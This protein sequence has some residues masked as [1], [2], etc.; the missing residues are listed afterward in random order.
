ATL[1]A[2]A[3]APTFGGGLRIAPDAV[4]DDGLMDVVIADELTPWQIIRLFPRLYNGS[5]VSNPAVHMMRARQV[6]IEP[7]PGISPPRVFG[8]GEDLSAL[9]L[10]ATM[11]HRAVPL[12]APSPPPRVRRPAHRR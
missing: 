8:D 3:N 10:T 5:H 12:L 11:M 9:P 4:F 7:G 6:T 1:V 2:L